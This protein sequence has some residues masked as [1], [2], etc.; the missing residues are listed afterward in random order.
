MGRKKYHALPP[1]VAL[2]YDLIN[3]AAYRE[4][5]S[6]AAKALPYFFAKVKKSYRDPQRYSLEFSLSYSEGKKYGFAPATFARVIRD[7]VRLGFVDPVDKGGLRSDGNSYN[8]FRLSQRWE[9]F[10]KPNFKKIDW[11]CFLPR[12]RRKPTSKK[13]TDRFN[14]GNISVAVEVLISENE[15]VGTF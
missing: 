10:G 6:S 9:D 14:K 11:R 13:E 7:L 12:S 2:P 5:P 8:L 15:A 4:L 3:S 1:F